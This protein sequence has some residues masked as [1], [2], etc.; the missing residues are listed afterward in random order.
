M[1]KKI[2][3]EDI[4]YPE[5]V[6]NEFIDFVENLTR[7]SPED[8]LELGDALNHPWLKLEEKVLY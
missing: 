7:K 6:S 3:W 4:V 8:R 2:V 5:Y 1:Y